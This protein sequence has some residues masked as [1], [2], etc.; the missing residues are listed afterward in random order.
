MKMKRIRVHLVFDYEGE[1]PY[2]IDITRQNPNSQQIKDIRDWVEK[3]LSEEI[4]R[5]KT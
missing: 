1:S 2:D 4:E 5:L 3:I